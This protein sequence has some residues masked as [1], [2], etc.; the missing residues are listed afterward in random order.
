MLDEAEAILDGIEPVSEEEFHP[1][2]AAAPLDDEPVHSVLRQR[3]DDFKAALSFGGQRK[4][5]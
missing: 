2:L 4:A 3:F 5:A 1:R